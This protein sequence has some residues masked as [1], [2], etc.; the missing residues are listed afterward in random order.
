MRIGSFGV[1]F[2][3]FLMLFIIVV[4]VIALDDT[5]FTLGSMEESNAT[6]W[7]G[8]DRTLVLFNSDFSPLA[9]ILCAGYFLHTCSLPIVRSSKNPDKVGRD[10][11]WGYFL[12]F[13][14]Y[15]VCGSLGYIGFLGTKFTSYFVNHEGSSTAGEIDQNCLNMFD[16][17]NVYAFILRLAIFL[18][19]FSTYP[20]VHYFLMNIL[21]I[22]FWRNQ[23]VPRR[24]EWILNVS[25][26]F[27]PFLFALFYPNI[28]TILSY[29]SAVSGF[30]V[31]YVFPV[32]VH[33]K[34][35]KTNITNP[36]LAEAIAMNAFNTKVRDLDDSIAIP[37]SP[38][39][40]ISDDLLR[41]RR[42]MLN[43]GQV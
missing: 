7:A 33:L 16:Y 20:L 30:A 26:T 35:M 3:I 9:G 1:I 25:I 42:S 32:L 17:L 22:L 15:A 4:G 19:L 6:N 12:V 8:P 24:T 13:I 31:I 21:M 34:R 14:S 28:G 18:L 2:V 29:V 5:T 11:F 41:K 37:L 10:M 38:Q 36:L 43:S 39:I 27:I 40:S 23:E